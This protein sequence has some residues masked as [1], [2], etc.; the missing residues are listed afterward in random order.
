PGSPGEGGWDEPGRKARC[1]P[2]ATAKMAVAS[3]GS[4]PPVV[5][6]TLSAS[7]AVPVLVFGFGDPGGRGVPSSPAWEDVG[8]RRSPRD[9]AAS[10][11][12]PARRQVAASARAR[13]HAVKKRFPIPGA[14]PSLSA[15]LRTTGLST[16]AQLLSRLGGAG[17]MPGKQSRE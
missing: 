13:N 2:P 15:R 5:P 7:P 4:G 16:M 11:P 17:Q 3:G 14:T 9:R 8:T 1:E 10:W 12:P 6:D